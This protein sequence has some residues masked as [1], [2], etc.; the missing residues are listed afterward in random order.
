MMLMPS[1]LHDQFIADASD[2]KTSVKPDPFTKDDKWDEWAKTFEEHLSL[3]PG[4]T[5]MPLAHVICK[6][7]EPQLLPAATNKENF[8]A[9]AKLPSK[10]FEIDSEKVHICLLPLLTEH[11]EAL[12]VVKGTGGD[13]KCCQSEW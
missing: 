3:L 6:D 7:E 12:S 5:G 9:V 11:S 13:T 1:E 8:I 2:N 10:T 4:S